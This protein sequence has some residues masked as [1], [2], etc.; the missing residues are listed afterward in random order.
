MK[1][2]NV[3]SG[4]KMKK[5]VFIFTI[6]MLVGNLSAADSTEVKTKVDSIKFK[7]DST[8]IKTPEYIETKSGLQ[9]LDLIIGEGEEAKSH[10]NVEVH[11]TGWLYID[12][13]KGTK[14]DS[15]YDRNKPISFKLGMGRLIQGWEEGIPGMKVGGKRILIIPPK[16]GYG[17]KA[18]GSIPSNSTLLFEVELVRIM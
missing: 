9:Y 16:L 15:S 18:V 8:E 2:S 6:I 1:L 4:V 17:K 5:T 12:G 10:D 3:K 7:T 14:F 13:Q 11:Y